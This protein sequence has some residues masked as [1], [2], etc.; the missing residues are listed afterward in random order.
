MSVVVDMV[1]YLSAA[2]FNL[3]SVGKRLPADAL[4]AS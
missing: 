4:E 2:D 1:F 3:I